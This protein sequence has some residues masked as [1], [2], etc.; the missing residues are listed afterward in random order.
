MLFPY[1]EITISLREYVLTIIND[2]PF[3]DWILSAHDI[4]EFL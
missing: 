3:V 4:K 1:G 2:E